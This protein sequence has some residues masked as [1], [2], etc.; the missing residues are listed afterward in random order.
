MKMKLEGISFAIPS[1]FICGV[2]KML[3]VICT[4]E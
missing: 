4:T 2:Q 3:D 1:A